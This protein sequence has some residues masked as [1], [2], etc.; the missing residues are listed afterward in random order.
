MAPP[1][2]N[3]K[4]LPT[5]SRKGSRTSTRKIGNYS[6]SKLVS[7]IKNVSL[8]QAETKMA[9]YNSITSAYHNVSFRYG[10]NLF[11]TAQ[12]ITDT[13]GAFNRIG[14]TV[15]PIGLKLYMQFRQPPDRPNVSWR[16]WVMKIIGNPSLPSSVPMKSVTGNLLLDPIDT[17]KC[18]LI[19]TYNFK[20]PDNYWAGTTGTS[21]DVDFF[22]KAWIPFRRTPYVYS[23]DNLDTG[24]DFQVCMFV[25]C[26]DSTG[27]LVSDNIGTF[28]CTNVFYFK[29]M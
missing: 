23:G 26:Y 28:Q 15:T 2:R 27:T 22:R 10:G 4:S 17:E 5:V 20:S 3:K 13:T 12:G 29:D 8:K 6:K 9:T 7:L 19:R 11:G 21:K 25:A 16:I 14:D 1:K 24:R 18:K